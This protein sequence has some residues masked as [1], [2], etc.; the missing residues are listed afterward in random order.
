MRSAH[1][2]T[3]GLGWGGGGDRKTTLAASLGRV[4]RRLTDSS[5]KNQMETEGITRKLQ[6][7]RRDWHKER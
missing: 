3:G 2:D 5:D 4:H 6:R 7:S 1:R